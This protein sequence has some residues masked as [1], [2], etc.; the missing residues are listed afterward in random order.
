MQPTKD[1]S[2]SLEEALKFG[3]A[4]SYAIDRLE[5]RGR[6]VAVT[7]QPTPPVHAGMTVE[8][9]TKVNL[10]CAFSMASTLFQL[11]PMLTDHDLRT[12]ASILG[13]GGAGES[14]QGSS[15]AAA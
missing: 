10:T 6:L 8:E 7:I 15:A 2:R 5:A 11:Y 1:F 3:E 12:V 4:L 13:I 14:G 9:L